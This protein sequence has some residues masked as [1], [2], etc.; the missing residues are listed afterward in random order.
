VSHR[1][2]PDAGIYCAVIEKNMVVYAALAHARAGRI[3]TR[4]ADTYTCP[5]IVLTDGR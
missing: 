3:E 5:G 2:S 4:R 1:A